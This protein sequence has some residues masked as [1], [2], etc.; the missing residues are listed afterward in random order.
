MVKKVEKRVEK[1]EKPKWKTKEI[2]LNKSGIIIKHF[3]K[4]KVG[5]GPALTKKKIAKISGFSKGLVY[6]YDKRPEILYEKKRSK[7][8]QEFID[9]IYKEAANK[10]LSEVN[11]RLLAEKVN[12]KLKNKNILIKKGKKKGKP[13]TISKSQI[14]RIL[15]EKF[16]KKRKVRKVI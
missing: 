8:P 12:R 2:K 11:G 10:K 14:N 4:K 6:Y 1:K 5:D 16:G 15:K 13:L 3:L 9:Y 7:L